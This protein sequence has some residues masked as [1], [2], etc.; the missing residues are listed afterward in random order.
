MQYT[1]I[2]AA[3]L[4]FSAVNAQISSRQTVVGTITSNVNTLI[5]TIT[6]NLLQLSAYF[7]ERLLKLESN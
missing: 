1:T 3:A 5:S 6:P 4:G 2:I 7:P